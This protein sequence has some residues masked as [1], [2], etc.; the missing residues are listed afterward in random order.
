MIRLKLDDRM[1]S[2]L[3]YYTTRITQPIGQLNFS[4]INKFLW[5]GSDKDNGLV[6]W[7]YVKIH[8]NIYGKNTNSFPFDH[9]LEPTSLKASL[10]IQSQQLWLVRREA[11]TVPGNWMGKNREEMKWTEEKTS[12]LQEE[13]ENSWGAW[14]A[15]SV[16][17]AKMSHL[18]LIK[19]GGLS[20][21]ILFHHFS[22]SSNRNDLR[23]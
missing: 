16:N 5:Y 20:P 9:E 12:T 13:E 11:L 14:L 23:F 21:L 1:K 7:L 4:L 19:M 22:P 8:F 3:R 17:S 10:C 18:L 2:G 6:I 15:P